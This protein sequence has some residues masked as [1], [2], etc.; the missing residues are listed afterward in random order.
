MTTTNNEKLVASLKKESDL[1]R[2]VHESFLMDEGY[3]ASNDC[4]Y[5]ISKRK[6][7][8]SEK[9]L[10]NFIA[11][12]S[13]EVTK[14]DGL[15]QE[16]YFQIKGVL[17]SG[18]PLPEVEVKAS[19]FDSMKW[20]P[21]LWGSSPVIN[22]GSNMH[23][24]VATAI[25]VKSSP[26]HEHIHAH[27]GWVTRDKALFYLHGGGAI[28]SSGSVDH[29]LVEV[30]GTLKKYN[31]PDVD[32][33]DSAVVDLKE[34]LECFSLVE[35]NGVGLLLF[36]AAF[37]SVLTEFR[38]VAFSLFLQGTTGTYKSCLAGVT[39][40]FFGADFDY[41]HLPA[42]WS[43]TANSNEKLAFLAKDSL[44]VVDDFVAT[45][46]P[47]GA[48]KAHAN[49]ERLFRS[50]GNLAGRGRMTQTSELKDGFVPRGL[51]LATGEDVPNGHSL[52]ARL[53]IIELQK[54][55]VDQEKLSQLQ[56]FAID[57]DLSLLMAEFL[58]WLARMEKV[59][60]DDGTSLP[61]VFKLHEK[62][63]NDRLIIGEQVHARQRSNYASLLLGFEVFAD[64]VVAVG[65]ME[66]PEVEEWHS[67]ILRVA[68]VVSLNQQRINQD[69]GIANRFVDLLRSCF[70]SG[71]THLVSKGSQEYPAPIGH[72]LGWRSRSIVTTDGQSSSINEPMG[73][74]VGWVDEEYVY[75][76]GQSV[77]AEIKTLSHMLGNHFGSATNSVYKA[78][79]EAHMLAKRDKDKHTYKTFIPGVGQKNTLCLPLSLFVE[80]DEY[81]QQDCPVEQKDWSPF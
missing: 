31:L 14:S 37:R 11:Y 26:K 10:S 50:Q 61:A 44:L 35:E 77:L 47:L 7:K 52:Q 15:L 18:K 19:E 71:R 42:N 72:A 32:S 69:S 25:K 81:H 53:V 74:L 34:I 45:G 20:V 36:C 55:Q 22:V 58:C 63:I 27:L 9:K 17:E 75:L 30:P 2:A 21:I 4:F 54:G 64:F 57:G 65:Y 29:M 13:R 79:F 48:T 76:D 46:G 59:Y 24:H 43:S 23:S 51:I 78:L 49:A 41:Q 1:T 28:G 80:R 62:R 12:I 67:K 66:R 70:S 68:E 39:Q 8:V 60:R 38:E 33:G 73:K 16:K 5:Y 56:G 3:L 40:A 6:E